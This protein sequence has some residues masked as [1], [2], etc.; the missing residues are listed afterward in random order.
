[1][2]FSVWMAEWVKLTTID[3]DCFGMAVGV[4][5]VVVGVVLTVLL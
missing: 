1:M 3:L 5:D 2:S 4:V